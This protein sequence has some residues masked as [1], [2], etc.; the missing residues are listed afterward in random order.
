MTAACSAAISTLPSPLMPCLHPLQPARLPGH[1]RRNCWPADPQKGVAPSMQ[2]KCT[3][4]GGQHN[5]QR[6]SCLLQPTAGRRSSLRVGDHVK[7]SPMMPEIVHRA[8]HCELLKQPYPTGTMPTISREMLSRASARATFHA[9]NPC[10][11]ATPPKFW[12]SVGGK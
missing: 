3:T 11:H 4:Q 7:D 12:L 9:T 6:S 5:V 10:R 1:R 2:L 8:L